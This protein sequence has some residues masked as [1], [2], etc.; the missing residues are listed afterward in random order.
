MYL[1][2]MESALSSE[3]QSTFSIPRGRVFVGSLQIVAQ[4]TGVLV[5]SLY[6]PSVR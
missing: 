2:S 1:L 6:D 5:L 3:G 4:A